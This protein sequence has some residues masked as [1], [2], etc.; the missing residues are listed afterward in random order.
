MD[1]MYQLLYYADKLRKD[2]G[3]SKH[4][5][6]YCF[7]IFIKNPGSNQCINTNFKAKKIKIDCVTSNCFGT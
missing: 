5:W 1:E 2:I 4:Y 6:N 3:Y 7:K